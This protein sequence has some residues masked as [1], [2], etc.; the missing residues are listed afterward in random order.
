MT[1]FDV[2][3]LVTMKE[4][5]IIVFLYNYCHVT[6]HVC[7]YVCAYVC[8]FALSTILIMTFRHDGT[9]YSNKMIFKTQI[10]IIFI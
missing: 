2:N 3:L 1:L 10:M 6:M 5:A 7:V 9:F 4:T 8:L